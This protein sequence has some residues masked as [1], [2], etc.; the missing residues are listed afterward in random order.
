MTLSLTS[1]WLL[2]L[3]CSV[4]PDGAGVA[5]FGSSTEWKVPVKLKAEE[6]PSLKY[7]FHF[8][9]CWRNSSGDNWWY[10]GDTHTWPPACLKPHVSNE[11]KMCVWRP[12]EKAVCVSDVLQQAVWIRISNPNNALGFKAYF[13]ANPCFCINFIITPFIFI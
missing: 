8:A 4:W 1:S 13:P 6:L 9:V 12:K 5:P 10:P 7:G 3:P 11:I 2:R